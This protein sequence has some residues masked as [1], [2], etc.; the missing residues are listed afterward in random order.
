MN[1][2]TK[3]IIAMGGMATAGAALVGTFAMFATEKLMKLALNRQDTQKYDKTKRKLSGS[4]K[5]SEAKMRA[6]EDGEKLASLE[7]RDVAIESFDGTVLAGHWYPCENAKR[8][9]IA[10]HG[11]RS[12]WYNNFGSVSEFWHKNGCSVLFAEQRGQGASGGDYM[13]FGILERYDCLEWARWAEKEA[14]C[15][16]P[17]YLAGVSMGASTVMMASCL[18]LPE[19]VKGIVADCG[20]TAPHDIWERVVEDKFHIP[21]EL[22]R[23][24]AD[25]ICRNKIKESAKAYS[26]KDALAA[27][28]VPVLFIHGTDDKFV[29]I[30]MTYENYKAC[31]SPKRLLV[32]PGAEHGMS[33]VVDSEKYAEATKIFW[34]ECEE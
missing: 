13:S 30:S 1:K 18:D 25:K 22:C 11:W 14:A 34:A 6:R 24:R 9:I 26:C 33:Y 16:L 20:F 8:V 3:S 29:P 21:Y 4:K 28:K 17:I 19:G 32:V 31:T 23:R 2:I 12:V 7:F 15:G 27:A 10:M 5:V